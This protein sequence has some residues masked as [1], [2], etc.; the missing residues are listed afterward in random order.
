LVSS[1]NF[2]VNSFASAP[3]TFSRAR[4]IYVRAVCFAAMHVVI[5]CERRQATDRAADVQQLKWRIE[6]V[7]Y[8]YL[9]LWLCVPSR[10]TNER[11]VENTAVARLPPER[12]QR[13]SR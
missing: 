3:A 7:S 1:A 11:D 9:Y 6:A 4:H 5:E 8:Y 13:V 10:S 2:P 12:A